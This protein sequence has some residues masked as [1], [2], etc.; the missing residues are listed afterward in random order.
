MQSSQLVYLV[1]QDDDVAVLDLISRTGGDLTQARGISGSAARVPDVENYTRDGM[2][3]HSGKM[4]AHVPTRSHHFHRN[5]PASKWWQFKI[6]GICFHF[7][8]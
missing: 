1:L 4:S 5:I 3:R 2:S 8:G 7:T 6:T